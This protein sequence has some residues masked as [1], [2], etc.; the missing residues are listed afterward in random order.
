VRD[1]LE[2]Q[3]EIV[4]GLASAAGLPIEEDPK[5]H[6]ASH[7]SVQPRVYEAYLRGRYQCSMRTEASLL[8]AVRDL[9]DALAL[10]AAYAPAYAALAD[11]Y[12][13]LGTVLVGNGSPAELRPKAARAA[14]HAL[15]ID[16]YLAEAHATLG[17]VRHYNWE[18]TAAERDFRRALELNPSLALA[19]VWYANLLA[20]L[21]RMD[22]ALREVEL[23]RDLDPFSPVVN[24][25]VGWTLSMAGRPDDAI[26][27]LTR[28]L[29]IDPDYPQA[30]LRIGNAY[31][32]V[33]R[34]GEGLRSLAANV[35]LSGRS[36]SAL[37][38]L[39]V[40][41]VRAGHP[42]KARALLREVLDAASRRYVPP[43]AI[44]AVYEALGEADPYFTWIERAFAE[45]A[46]GL[47]Y[48]RLGAANSRFRDDPRHRD[49]VRRLGGG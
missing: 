5:A 35:R 36:P 19:H 38:Y 24:T 22:D 6:L 40:G 37:A 11:C 3:G 13:Q 15:Q 29:A 47:A 20:S 4:R 1:V 16:P 39:A 18:W 43:I 33:G 46:N 21:G 25:N 48:A 2:L 42:R 12:N 14:I 10:D 44:A 27:Q 17:Y 8:R 41:Y 26:A 45:R 30:H 9:E 7:R 32:A 49:L 31:L 23:A 34:T 28:T